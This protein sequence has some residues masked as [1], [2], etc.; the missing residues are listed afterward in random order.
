MVRRM[1]M[2][3]MTNLANSQRAVRPMNNSAST[4]QSARPFQHPGVAVCG[5]VR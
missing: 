2:Y 5:V 1:Y 3:E 4:S